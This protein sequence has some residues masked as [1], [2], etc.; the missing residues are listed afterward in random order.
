M[1]VLIPGYNYDCT[2]QSRKT[3]FICKFLKRTANGILAKAKI[4]WAILDFD[5]SICK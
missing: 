4:R 2:A 3:T 5:N 1:L